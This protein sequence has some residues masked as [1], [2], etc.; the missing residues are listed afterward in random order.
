MIIIPNGQAKWEKKQTNDTT[1]QV[2]RRII[3]PCFN[4]SKSNMSG[5]ILPTWGI[6]TSPQLLYPIFQLLLSCLGAPL[7]LF[8]CAPHSNLFLI[9]QEYSCPLV[10]LRFTSVRCTREHVLRCFT[11]TDLRVRG[12]YMYFQ[13]HKIITSCF[14]D[15]IYWFIF[16]LEIS[17]NL[18][19]N[20]QSFNLPSIK[21]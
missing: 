10:T 9:L 2:I 15:L 11:C 18:G 8:P 21:E 5:L 6:R 17:P 20:D 4:K 14:L 19:L 3:D 12:A 13:A 1:I 16:V 7:Y